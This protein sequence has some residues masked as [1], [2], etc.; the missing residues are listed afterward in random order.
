MEIN[1]IARELTSLDE[2]QS[3]TKS[4]H[5]VFNHE[6]KFSSPTDREATMES[7][8]ESLV[9]DD[10]SRLSPAELV[11]NRLTRMLRDASVPVSQMQARNLLR[12]R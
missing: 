6:P 9:I 11:E 10:R 2:N 7:V 1:P 5:V 12:R 4:T 8:T 3:F